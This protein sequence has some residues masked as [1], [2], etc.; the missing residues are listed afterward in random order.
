LR[1]L[2]DREEKTMKAIIYTILLFSASLVHAGMNHIAVQTNLFGLDDTKIEFQTS[3]QHI[4]TILESPDGSTLY[5][6]QIE[7]TESENE[8]ELKITT[9]LSR[10]VTE[11]S[12]WIGFSELE[13][14]LS[15]GNGAV[16]YKKDSEHFTISLK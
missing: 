6:L 12:P 14:T 7:V 9:S 8:G 13:A 16:I 4:N 1:Q 2:Y 11:D 15:K 3:S 10:R 5:N